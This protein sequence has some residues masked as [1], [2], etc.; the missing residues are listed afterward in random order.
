MSWPSTRGRRGA[1]D[2]GVEPGLRAG[3]EGDVA[4]VR[5][6]Q[7]SRSADRAARV[8]ARV[9]AEPDVVVGLGVTGC[10]VSA[11]GKVRD[12]GSLRDGLEGQE[13][14]VRAVWSLGEAS[15]ARVAVPAGHAGR[16]EAAAVTSGERRRSPVDFPF[17]GRPA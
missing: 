17:R 6:V 9:V 2:P 12:L 3:A 16:M 14:A 8:L 10:Y 1:W 5:L 4:I 13:R 11:R 15:H 7:R